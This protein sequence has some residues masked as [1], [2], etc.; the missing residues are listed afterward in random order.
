M[1]GKKKLTFNKKMLIPILIALAISVVIIAIIANGDNV[2]NLYGKENTSQNAGVIIGDKAYISEAKI[3]QIIT[4]TGP[5]DAN[6]NAGNDSSADN[7]IV[8]SFDQVTWNVDITMALKSGVS[9]GGLN[10]GTIDF[11]VS[12]PDSLANIVKWDLNSMTWVENAQLS[13]DGTKL[14]GSYSM[15][16]SKQSVPGKQTLIFIL[17][18]GGATNGTE[19]APKFNFKLA[20]N[21]DSEKASAQSSTVIVSSIPKYDISIDDLDMTYDVDING[22]YQKLYKY[23]LSFKLLG[24][25]TSKGVKGIE[26]PKN[27]LSFDIKYNMKRKPISGSDYTDITKNLGLY[28]YKYNAYDNKGLGNPENSIADIPDSFLVSGGAYPYSTI[29][30]DV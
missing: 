26:I 16:S 11:E 9:V 20:G 6:D 17:K 27:N 15:D 25:N 13:S 5:W 8:R 12:L 24:D 4:G 28:N 1:S 3:M 22:N 10:G 30:G 7:N 29:V 18:V 14:T 2:F 19:I 23:G 21:N